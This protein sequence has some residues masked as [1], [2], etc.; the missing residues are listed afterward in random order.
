MRKK[1]IILVVVVLLLFIGIGVRYISLAK[2]R[3]DGEV[4]LSE[5]ESEGEAAPMSEEE[6]E[7]AENNSISAQEYVDLVD[8][9]SGLTEAQRAQAR[10]RLIASYTTADGGFDERRMAQAI[11]QTKGMTAKRQEAIYDDVQPAMGRSQ[12]RRIHAFFTSMTADE[13]NALLDR[14]IE[15]EEQFKEWASNNP[16]HP[17]V[18]RMKA[19]RSRTGATGRTGNRVEWHMARSLYYSSPTSRAQWAEFGRRVDVR[20]KELKLPRSM[21]RH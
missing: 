12:G 18:K 17:W 7:D 9:G 8:G 3:S 11:S 6:Y 2:A 1:N 20:R 19:H 15:Q 10:D 21:W 5:L 16:N 13:Q 14:S 4:T